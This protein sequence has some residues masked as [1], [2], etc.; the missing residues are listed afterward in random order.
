VAFV[1]Y[2]EKEEE[3]LPR[4]DTEFHGEENSIEEYL[5]NMIQL[6]KNLT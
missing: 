4:S 2:V 3:D 5:L 1:E 6:H